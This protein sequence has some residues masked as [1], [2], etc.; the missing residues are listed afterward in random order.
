META[1]ELVLDLP[2]P[3]VRGRR[4]A[5]HA[6]LRAAILEGRLHAGLRLPPS[7]NLAGDLRLSR[8]AV[9]AVYDLLTA[10]GLVRSRAGSGIFVA[11]P[12][13]PPA[14]ALAGPALKGASLP[15]IAVPTLP[16]PV[17]TA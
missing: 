14:A 11:P 6:Q 12:P 8:N 16:T 1:L 7:R 10:E 13:K 9:L 5:L 17:Q 4:R 3:G 15:R 2:A